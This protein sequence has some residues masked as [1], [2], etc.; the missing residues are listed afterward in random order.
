MKIPRPTLLVISLLSLTGSLAIAFSTRWGPWAFSDSTEFIV[1]ARNLLAGKGLGL[2]NPEGVFTPLTLHPP[3]YPLLLSAFG[4]VGVDLL[5][6]TR[7][8]NVILFGA[9]IYIAGAIPYRLFKSTWLAVSSSASVLAMST[10]VDVFS[11]AMSEPLFTF[12]STL[13]I[14][15]LAVYLVDGGHRWLVVS[16][17]AAGLAA[18]SRYPGAV[19]IAAGMVEIILLTSTNWKQRIRDLLIYGSISLVPIGI[20]LQWIFSQSQSPRQISNPVD[21]GQ[22]FISLRLGLVEVFWSW[23]PFT[24]YLPPYSYNLALHVLLAMGALL[25]FGFIFTLVKVWQA[26]RWK[27]PVSQEFNFVLLWA[28]VILAYLALLAFSYLFGSPTPDLIPR[29]LL[30]MQFFL[31]FFLL[32]SGLFFIKE[33]RLPRWSALIP[34]LLAVPFIISNAQASWTLIRS[35]YQ[36]G[37][38]YTAMSWRDSNTL[39]EVAKLPADLP[40]ITN[41]A[42]GLLLWTD[43]AAY[44][45]CTLPCNQPGDARYGDNPDDE[46]QRIFRQQGAALVLFYPFCAPRDEGWNAE[47]MAQLDSLT[48][49]LTCLEYSC[50]GAIYLYP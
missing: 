42:A 2:Y 36:Q 28:A 37:A 34:V 21:L 35:Y 30:P 39:V 45:F 33:L 6:T 29:T 13:S 27:W 43:R 32:G 25:A 20:W 11:G 5:V 19:L 49:G 41:E 26:G 40:I 31:G 1:S 8:L 50:D 17:I 10:L 23:L 3:F 4:L 46:V 24:E 9:T 16:A 22:A 15:L 7:W 14:C 48:N 38:G 44:D 12:T 47:R 18:L